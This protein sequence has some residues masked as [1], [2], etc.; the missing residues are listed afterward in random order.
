MQAIATINLNN[1]QLC[2]PTSRIGAKPDG[3]EIILS[4]EKATCETLLNG[5]TY[6]KI[7]EICDI[8]ADH[9]FIQTE[10]EGELT[11]QLHSEELSAIRSHTQRT[12]E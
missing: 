9:L 12:N 8:C 3:G 4:M 7:N 11:C 6:I 5:D 10:L 1:G 2:V